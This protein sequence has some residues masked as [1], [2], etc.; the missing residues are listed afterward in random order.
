[1]EL[2]AALEYINQV[3]DRYAKAE[4]ECIRE[5][6]DEAIPVLLER[7]KST[8]ENAKNDPDFD[9]DGRDVYAM[10]LLAEFRVKEAFP[11]LIQYLDLDGDKTYDI[12]SDTLT[13]GFASILASCATSDDV[14]TL[15]K[16]VLNDNLDEFNRMTA[17]D[18]IWILFWENVVSRDYFIQFVRDFI[19]SHQQDVFDN[20]LDEVAF[21]VLDANITE[22]FDDVRTVCARPRIKGEERYF[23]SYE[24]F[25]EMLDGASDLKY[26]RDK[27]QNHMLVEDVSDYISWW[28]CFKENKQK[29]TP[30]SP[31]R[32]TKVGRNEPCPCGSGKK[33]KKCCGY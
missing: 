22:L 16:Y 6:R 5:N 18:A 26:D 21:H 4:I 8:I 24:S 28:H 15:K 2:K 33:Y 19:T 7:V 20:L 25:C 10:F 32:T 3:R 12:L 17:L 11:H 9:Y 31:A 27:H 30:P 13:E 1:M 29:M 23:E 14:P